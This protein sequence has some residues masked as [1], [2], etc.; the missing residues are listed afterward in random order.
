MQNA[1]ESPHQ[2][3]WQPDEKSL[4]VWSPKQLAPRKKKRAT[5]A[6]ARVPVTGTAVRSR[7]GV[8]GRKYPAAAGKA[9]G[10]EPAEHYKLNL[11]E[12]PFLTGKVLYVFFVAVLD[13]ILT[14][15]TLRNF[16]CSL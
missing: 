12:I 3:S 9:A 10:V 16:C 6:R 11:A 7:S 8:V 2:I 13:S 1:L 14:Q 4:P 5:S 15:G